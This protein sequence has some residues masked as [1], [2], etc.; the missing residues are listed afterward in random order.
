[1][2][3]G[4]PTPES[5]FEGQPKYV[6]FWQRLLKRKNTTNT[7]PSTKRPKTTT[8]ESTKIETENTSMEEEESSVKD[9]GE[10]VLTGG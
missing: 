6:P 9:K 10:E 2:L 1:M 8:I 7:T 5:E 3:E 4:P